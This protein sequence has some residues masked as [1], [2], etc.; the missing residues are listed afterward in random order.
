MRPKEEKEKEKTWQTL[1]LFDKGR[2]CRNA[3]SQ[4]EQKKNQSFFHESKYEYIIYLF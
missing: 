3:S 4:N 2:P 1:R